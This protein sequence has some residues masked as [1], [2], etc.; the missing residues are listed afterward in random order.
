MTSALDQSD[1]NF[2]VE[3]DCWK[4]WVNRGAIWSA[5]SFNTCAASSSGPVTLS[6]LSSLSCLATPI[7]P[8]TRS[9]MGG[10]GDG[11]LLGSGKDSLVNADLNILLRKLDLLWSVYV[12]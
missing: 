7:V 6:G 9:L 3:Y 11:P 4:R 12:L 8:I 5:V 1:V 2:P 10:N